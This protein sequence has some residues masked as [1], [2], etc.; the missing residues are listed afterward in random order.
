MTQQR[1]AT[2]TEPERY[3]EIGAALHALASSVVRRMPRDISLTT[4]ATLNTLDRHGAQ[5]LTR[6]AELE[7]VTQPSMTALVTRLE[8]DG[9][10]VRRPDPTDGRAV[11]VAL[12]AAGK[13]YVRRRRQLGASALATRIAELPPDDQQTLRAALPAIV[14]LAASDGG[15]ARDAT[16]VA[17]PV[18]ANGHR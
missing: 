13:R 14:A 15:T 11:L 10:A 4:A 2:G 18:K 16:P 7:G 3:A 8:G 12:T 17:A 1:R 6:L 9:F 5:R